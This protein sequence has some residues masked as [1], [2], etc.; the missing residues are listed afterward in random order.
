[1][2]PYY[3]MQR[4]YVE[5]L[6]APGQELRLEKEQAHYLLHVLRLKPGRD[7]LLFD[8]KNGEWRAVCAK[9]DKKSISFTIEEQTRPQPPSAAELIYCFAPLKQARLDYMAQKAAEMGASR[10]QPVLTQ[11]TQVSRLNKERL[12]ANSIE[13][14]EQ[15]GLLTLPDCAAPQSLNALLEGWQSQ[16]GQQAKLIFCDEAQQ[17]ES[18][19]NKTAAAHNPLPFL[20]RL[21]TA[22]EQAGKT[23]PAIG[24]LIGPEGGFSEAERKLL[25]GQ[26]FVAAIPLGPRILRT[27]TAAVAALALIQAT[28]GDW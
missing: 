14:A 19:Q 10:L 27:D 13:A 1:M 8:G 21:N 18:E 15:C 3:K 16:Y 5:N 4:L 2:R 23:A 24:L 28:L 7:I 22:S 25:Y 9:A 6:P 12:R 26:D 17:S 11:H 20:Q